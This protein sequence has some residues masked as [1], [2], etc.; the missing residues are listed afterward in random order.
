MLRW[1][2]SFWCLGDAGAVAW[3]ERISWK[4]SLSKGTWKKKRF[5]LGFS[6]LYSVPFLRVQMT[7]WSC[8]VC[9]ACA[10]P[11]PMYLL[12]MGQV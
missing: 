12:C 6:S 3:G 8:P 5:P 11:A 10:G 4:R 9:A 7:R 2:G 1:I